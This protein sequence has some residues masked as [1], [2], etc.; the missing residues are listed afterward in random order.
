V[1]LHT[2]EELRL[3]RRGDLGEKNGG[4]LIFV[5]HGQ[6]PEYVPWSDVERIVFE[7]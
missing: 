7:R 6:Q 4:M 2:G 1:T 5:E 3:D